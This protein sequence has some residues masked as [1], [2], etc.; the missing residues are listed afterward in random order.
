MIV[1]ASLMVATAILM[2]SHSP[3]RPRRSQ[4]DV[5]GYMVATA[6][7]TAGLVDHGI[8]GIAIVSVLALKLIGESLND[9][10]NP[11]AQRGALS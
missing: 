4:H 7:V 9:S 11:L 3:S 8:P 2:E 1:L 6:H 10:F 5:V